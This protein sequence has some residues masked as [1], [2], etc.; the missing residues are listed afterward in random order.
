M[1]FAE[2]IP[3]WQG[4]LHFICEDDSFPLKIFSS[5]ECAHI[6]FPS[7]RDDTAYPMSH[8][9]ALFWP[10]FWVFSWKTI[11]DIFCKCC[12]RVEPA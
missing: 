11:M 10:N 8:Y 2:G 5:H 4:E 3:A 9:V 6:Y 12:Q 1:T 7:E